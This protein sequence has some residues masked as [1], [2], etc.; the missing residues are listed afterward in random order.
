M[1]IFSS[2][3]IWTDVLL[4]DEVLPEAGLRDFTFEVASNRQLPLYRFILFN[5]DSDGFGISEK[6]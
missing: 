6:Y 2:G 4:M 1:H 5:C 3:V